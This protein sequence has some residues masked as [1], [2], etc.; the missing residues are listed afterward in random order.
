VLAGNPYVRWMLFCVTGVAMEHEVV[1]FAIK[2]L[3]YAIGLLA[4]VLLAILFFSI[5]LWRYGP[6]IRKLNK[7][8]TI[9]Q[10]SY[11]ADQQKGMTAAFGEA[12]ASSHQMRQAANKALAELETLRDF[13][14]DM[15][16]K[17]SEYNADAIVRERLEEQQEPGVIW[18]RPKGEQPPSND[19]NA[20][21]KS[22]MAEW[23]KFLAVFRQRLLDANITPVMNR[24]GKMTYQLTDKR[25]RT[26]LP[27]ET[28][29]LIT[30]LH[31]Q[32][33]RYTRLQGTKAQWLTSIIHDDF[34]R[35]V[36][37]AVRELSRPISPIEGDAKGATAP[38]NGASPRLN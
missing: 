21:Y 3:P 1:A 31:S 38:G 35:L 20:L 28:A 27:I 29:E 34:V 22:M 11:F 36:E 10:L 19:P 12:T 33:K 23:E 5:Q 13:V 2:F 8:E 24:I 26:P 4:T 6:D 14:T 7:F 32:Y 9:A 30:A 17:M 15:R 16:E 18:S 25:R 37:T